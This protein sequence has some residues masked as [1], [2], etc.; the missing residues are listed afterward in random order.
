MKCFK[1]SQLEL[2]CFEK[3]VSQ[4]ELRCFKES[5]LELKRFE[6]E[7]RLQE[8]RCF[9]YVLLLELIYSRYN[10]MLLLRFFEY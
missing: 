9:D 2:K 5:Q 3:E 10:S 1:E 4:L 7:V 8:L 6:K